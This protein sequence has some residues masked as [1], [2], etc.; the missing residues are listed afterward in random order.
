MSIFFSQDINCVDCMTPPSPSQWHMQPLYTFWCRTRMQT[1]ILWLFQTHKPIQ[2]AICMHILSFQPPTLAQNALGRL[3][4]C[5]AP[6]CSSVIHGQPNPSLPLPAGSWGYGGW[7][8]SEGQ[9]IMP[10]KVSPQVNC[11]N[12]HSCLVV[13]W[14]TT[15][16]YHRGFASGTCTLHF[17]T[18]NMN[19]NMYIMTFSN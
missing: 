14:V 4:L 6:P 3:S 5:M 16:F 13:G 7:I 12:G 19:V 15:S 11:F 2:R 9:H 1:C 8:W 18:P 10:R 17:L